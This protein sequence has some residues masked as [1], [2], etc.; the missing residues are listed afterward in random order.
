MRL[1]WGGVFLEM[2]STTPEIVK[3]DGYLLPPTEAEFIKLLETTPNAV[4][5]YLSGKTCPSCTKFYPHLKELDLPSKAPK[6]LFIKMQYEDVPNTYRK[7]Y[8]KKAG[9]VPSFFV[10]Y[11]GTVIRFSKCTDFGVAAAKYVSELAAK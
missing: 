7:L 8:E 10:V 4:F 5:V 3:K 6:N 1:E 9:G 11:R 2:A